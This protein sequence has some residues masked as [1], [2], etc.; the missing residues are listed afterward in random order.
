M[1]DLQL[2][3]AIALGVIGVTAK[4]V[5][6]EH[7]I[8]MGIRAGSDDIEMVVGQIGRAIEGLPA[9]DAEVP[10][11]NVPTGL[12]K[13]DCIRDVGAGWHDDVDVN[14]RLRCQAG[15]AV[16]PTRSITT[17]LPTRRACGRSF[18]DLKKAGQA[19]SYATTVLASGGLGPCRPALIF[20][21][22]SV[23]DDADLFVF[24]I[25]AN[26]AGWKATSRLSRRSGCPA[27]TEMGRAQTSAATP[28]RWEGQDARGMRTGGPAFNSRRMSGGEGPVAPELFGHIRRQLDA[29]L[30]RLL[31]NLIAEP[32]SDRESG[33]A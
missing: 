28:A 23:P 1:G 14:D 11:V 4:M 30:V 6:K 13:A 31:D 12:E 20:I 10:A 9:G 24:W 33:P 29:K 27:G 26:V 2:P 8:K 5:A 3:S 32:S 19:V 21:G 25:S 18:M 16:L 7:V 17:S 22:H 15:T